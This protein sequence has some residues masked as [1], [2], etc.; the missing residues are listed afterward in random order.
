MKERKNTMCTHCS[1]PNRIIL[2][3]L[4]FVECPKCFCLYYEDNNRLVKDGD[5][6]SY[7]IL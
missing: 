6:C 4:V 2:T 3:G 7:N 1:I 5:N